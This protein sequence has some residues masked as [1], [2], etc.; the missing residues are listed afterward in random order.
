MANNP[1]SWLSA[2][3]GSDFD[4]SSM[5][6]DGWRRRGHEQAMAMHNGLDWKDSSADS[7]G[8]TTGGCLDGDYTDLQKANMWDKVDDEYFEA[9]ID[10]LAR[11]ITGHE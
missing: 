2:D 6:A 9:E 3:N 1:F 7:D 10:Q 11:K 5:T 8:D 4:E